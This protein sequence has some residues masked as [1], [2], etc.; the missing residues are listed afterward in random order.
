MSWIIVAM[1]VTAVAGGLKAYGQY[2]QGQEQQQYYNYLADV[3]RTKGEYAYRTGMK[4]SELTQ[5]KAKYEAMLQKR[6]VVQFASSQRATM[7]ANGI[8]LA[9]VSAADISSDTMSKAFMDQMVIRYNADS[10]S[11]SQ[12][13]EAQYKKWA[14]EEEARGNEQAGK[15]AAAS[16]K[17]AAFTTLLATA[18]SVA[19]M[20]VMGGVGGAAGGGSSGGGTSNALALKGSQGAQRTNSFL[21]RG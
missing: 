15:Q 2:K 9:S 4:E 17:R 20:G 14:G 6:N 21:V 7:I 1:G 13:T 3:S 5:D 8:D 11:W 19:F 18:G 12:T 16:G 10:K